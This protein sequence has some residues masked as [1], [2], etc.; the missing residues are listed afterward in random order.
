MRRL[1]ADTAQQIGRSRAHFRKDD[2][3]RR[4][5]ER[6]RAEFGEDVIQQPDFAETLESILPDIRLVELDDRGAVALPGMPSSEAA[7]LRLAGETITGVSIPEDIRAAVRQDMPSLSTEQLRAMEAAVGDGRRMTVIEGRAGAGKSYTMRSIKMA[8]ERAGF[9]VLGIALSWNAASV[10]M[11][12]TDLDEISSIEGMVRAMERAQALGVEYFRRPT[13]IIVDEGGMVGTRHMFALASA[14]ATSKHPV[15]IVITGDSLQV[16]P[17]E[18]GNILEAI[19]DV[20]GSV[21][22]DT[23]R[24]QLRHSHREA[25]TAFMNRRA[26]KGLAI[27]EQQEG[28]RWCENREQAFDRAAAEYL[29]FRLQNPDQEALVLALTNKDVLAVNERLRAAFRRLGKIDS[30]EYKI[31]VTDG[32]E[33]WDALFAV[34]DEIVFRHNDRALVICDTQ[35]GD[36]RNTSSWKPIRRGLYN[37]NWG[38]IVDIRPASKG[39]PAGSYDIVVHLGGP[40]PGRV[41]VNSASLRHPARAGFPMCHNYASTI[42]GAQGKTVDRTWLIDHPRMNFRLAYVGMSRHRRGATIILDESEIHARLDAAM[43]RVRAPL[44]TPQPPSPHDAPPPEAVRFRYTRHQML[45]AVAGT[46]S[47]ESHNETLHMRDKRIRFGRAAGAPIED[48]N[49]LRIGSSEDPQADAPPEE[50]QETAEIDWGALLGRQPPE[51]DAVL[52]AVEAERNRIEEVPKQ[53]KRTRTRHVTPLEPA[54]PGNMWTRL[55]RIWKE[56]L[57]EEENATRQAFTSHHDA[58]APFGTKTVH[59]YRIENGMIPWRPIIPRMGC[60]T[61]E[62]AWSWE[63]V[64]HTPELRLPSTETMR[65]HQGVWWS[66][67]P[68]GEPRVLVRNRTGEIV[69]RYRLDGTLMAGQGWPPLWANPA[70]VATAPILIVPGAAEFWIMMEH[71]RG[72]HAAKPKERPHLIWAARDTD[73]SLMQKSF[74]LRPVVVVRSRHDAAQAA[75][76]NDL[77]ERIATETGVRPS[78]RPTTQAPQPSAAHRPPRPTR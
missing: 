74:A 57:A 63:G 36:L 33:T 24:R 32:R 5:L 58:D 25:V 14:A 30:R 23:I 15:K 67:G 59:P 49:R 7:V 39:A 68:R 72:K 16:T 54:P 35:E 56:A 38:E 65:H 69:A 27:Y 6:A 21:R 70:A 19:V 41:L 71:L 1:L 77:A 78:I 17:T 4:A 55:G 9:D 61:P 34:G 52:R 20:H 64:P 43:N 44:T 45:R 50:F 66:L 29:S 12:E 48:L 60:V 10:L 18:A 51:D 8:F 11:A 3:I 62:G 26:G 42:Y 73:W 2:V 31:R 37:R 75:W 28:L 22:L 13:M 47:Q 76:A 46:W 40:R 53:P